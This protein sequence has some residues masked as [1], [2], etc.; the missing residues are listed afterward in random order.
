M[1]VLIVVAG[2]AVAGWWQL[3]AWRAQRVDEVADRSGRAPVGLADVLQPDA[4]LTGE[5]VGVPVRVAGAY[6][7]RDAQFLVSGRELD[8]ASGYWVLSPLRVASGSSLLVVRGWQPGT[9]MPPVPAGPVDETGVLLPGEEGAADVGPDRVVAS[10]RIPALVG[11]TGT[12]LYGA[13]LLRTRA[14]P[15]DPAR[16][17]PVPPPQAEATWGAGLRNLA[18]AAQWWLF[19]AFAL[20]LWARACT[21]R[22]AAD[23]RERLGTVAR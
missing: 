3:D 1:A 19:G 13:F 20:L 23:R 12:D 9:G 18:Y 7:P 11:E 10:V 22:V 15:V 14:D 17:A 8:G 5:D 2:T 6:A 16:L 21:D 4:A